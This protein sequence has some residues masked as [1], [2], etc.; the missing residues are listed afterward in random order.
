[1]QKIFDTHVHFW[2]T[3][4]LNLPWLAEIP[5]LDAQYSF[6]DY[7]QATQGYDVAQLTYVEVDVAK[8]EQS[9]KLE[10][11]LALRLA[12]E[13]SNINSLVLGADLNDPDF[14]AYITSLSKK[15][16]VVGI[17]HGGAGLTTADP[18]YAPQF[19]ENVCLAGEL[20]LL[21]ELLPKI[22]HI[23]AANHLVEKCPNTTFVI[24]HCGSI[25]SRE[26][27]PILK[28]FWQQGML[29]YSQQP[30]TLCKISG[31][32][33]NE[34]SD[35]WT[36]GNLAPIVNFCLDSF[37]EDRV[38]FASNWPVCNLNGSFSRWIDALE[39]IVSN[40]EISCKNK[41]FYKNGQ[42]YYCR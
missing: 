5:A 32:L 3:H 42:R 7:Q 27:N 6:S 38:V 29:N 18:Y 23:G 8:D 12:I 34:P 24:D 39:E 16:S 1:M 22:E 20:G 13:H 11:L 19:I 35:D 4:K 40:R 17:R 14:A 37:G 9:L 41:L 10:A 15:K 25:G 36:A 21:V 2:D 33:Q 31:L 28:K 30:N 26:Q